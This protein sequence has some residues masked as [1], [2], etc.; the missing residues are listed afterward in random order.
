[1]V[2]EFKDENF[3]AEVIKSDQPVLVDFWATWCGPCKMLGPI[4][5][6]VAE[7]Y[8]D[9]PVKIGKLE[10]DSN[11]ATPGKYQIMSVPTLMIFKNGE[12]VKQM[13]GV[14]PKEDIM[15]ALDEAMA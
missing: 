11:E 9:K 15:A 8:K 7:E 2:L 5:E 1:M 3:E 14:Q 12:P 6:E 4:V 13:V 10:V